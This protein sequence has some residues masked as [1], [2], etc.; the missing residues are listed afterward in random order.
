MEA[1][2]AHRIAYSLGNTAPD[3]FHGI[4]GPNYSRPCALCLQV[5]GLPKQLFDNDGPTYICEACPAG[6]R[7]ELM[8]T[9]W[10]ILAGAL[11]SP[12]FSNSLGQRLCA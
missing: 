6:Q 1:I 12:W 2:Y 9:N 3:L 10:L 4:A 7:V 5:P 11:G 8:G